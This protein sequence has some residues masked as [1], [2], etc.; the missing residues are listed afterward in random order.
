[1]TLDEFAATYVGDD[2]VIIG[3]HDEDDRLRAIFD[4]SNL[5]A[6]D[7]YPQMRVFGWEMDVIEGSIVVT[8]Y[9]DWGE[10]DD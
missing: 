7:L 2:N 5:E 9:V 8:A 1:M 10:D 6:I 3:V 4:T